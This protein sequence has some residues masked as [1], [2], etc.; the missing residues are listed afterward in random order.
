MYMTPQ[1]ISDQMEPLDDSGDQWSQVGDDE[2]TPADC[3]IYQADTGN[4]R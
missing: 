3:Y 4:Q 2:F 1:E